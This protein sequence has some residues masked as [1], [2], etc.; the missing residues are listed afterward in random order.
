MTEDATPL[1]ARRRPTAIELAH[2]QLQGIRAFHAARREVERSVAVR[3]RSR[4]DMLDARR[5]LECLRR[6]H[7]ALVARAD[8]HLRASVDVLVSHVPPRAVLAHRN[9]WFKAEVDDCLGQ[10]GIRVVATV[11]DGA[12]AV[13]VA[14]AEQPDVLLVEDTLPTMRGEEVV[15][16]VLRLS[17]G[18]TVVAHVSH[19]AGVAAMLAAGAAAAWARRVPPG[20]V[21]RHMAELVSASAAG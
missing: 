3:A 17:P 4:E 7:A 8:E 21:G 5:R 9:D 6:Q 10:H 11:A 12:D 15:R 2:A 1:L 16:E 14:A 20:E 19:D 13:G 18:S